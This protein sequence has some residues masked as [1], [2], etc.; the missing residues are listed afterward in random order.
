MKQNLLSSI[1]YIQK[2][3]LLLAK[4]ENQFDIEQNTRKFLNIYLPD[5][6]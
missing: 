3:P 1:W 5:F 6:H 2:K 4:K